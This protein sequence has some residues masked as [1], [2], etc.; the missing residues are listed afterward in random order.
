MTRRFIAAFLAAHALAH[1][2]GFAWPWWLIEPG[3]YATPA[4]DGAVFIGDAAMNV[5]SALWLVTASMFGAAALAVLHG[6]W[7]WRRITAVAA[8]ASLV[9]SIICWPG[10]LMGIP[11]NVAIL[12]LLRVTSRSHWPL[13]RA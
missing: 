1:L 13:A 3:P 12:T 11:I 6:H 4:P 9:L 2:V 10:S 8:I 7:T 5:M